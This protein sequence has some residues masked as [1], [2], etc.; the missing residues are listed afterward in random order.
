LE[1]I[2]AIFT[3]P[4]PETVRALYEAGQRDAY[5]WAKEHGWALPKKNGL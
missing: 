5:A 1:T 4:K 3:P 2:Y